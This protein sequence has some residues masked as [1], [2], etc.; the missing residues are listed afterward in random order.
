MNTMTEARERLAVNTKLNIDRDDL[1]QYLYY[2]ERLKNCFNAFITDKFEET[3]NLDFA[4]STENLLKLMKDNGVY[5]EYINEYF[6]DF[7]HDYKME[8]D[9]HY[10]NRYECDF[11]TL[12]EDYCYNPARYI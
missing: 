6:N 11:P 3:L 5:L 10:R 4:I 1:D 7:F 9:E 2:D 8:F 12:W